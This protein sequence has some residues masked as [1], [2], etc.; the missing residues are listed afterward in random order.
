MASQATN[1]SVAHGLLGG[2]GLGMVASDQSTDAVRVTGWRLGGEAWQPGRLPPT[3]GRPPAARL[4]AME[5][6]F[7]GQGVGSGWRL[8]NYSGGDEGM[9]HR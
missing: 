4:A 2:F 3:T 6:S 7:T 9:A 8:A 1:S 5:R